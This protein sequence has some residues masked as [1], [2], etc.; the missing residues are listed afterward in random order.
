MATA[1]CRTTS[2]P[3]C[4][5]LEAE[6]FT[7]ANPADVVVETSTEVGEHVQTGKQE[8]WLE[9]ALDVPVAGRYRCEFLVSAT[10]PEASCWL[11]DYPENP[12]GRTYNITGMMKIPPADD[13]ESFL[14][15]HRDGAPL[16]RGL[17][18]VRFHF[19]GGP[20]SLDWIRLTL[21]REHQPTPKTLVQVMSGDEWVQKWSDE[22]DGSGVPDPSI[23]THDIGNWG[24][25]NNE[26]Q[27]YTENREENARL[28]D[29]H[30]IIEARKNDL[31]QPWT[32]ARLTTRGKLSFLYGKIEI[33]AKAPAGQG[34]WAAG[35]TLGDAYVDEKSWPYCGEIDILECVGR[36]VDAASGRGVNH[37]S[38][39]TRAYYFKQGNQISSTI[40]V[41]NMSEEFHTYTVEWYPDRIEA[42]VDGEHY[43][44]YD[45]TN[46][47]WE[48]P[49]NQSQNLILNLAMGGGMGGEIDPNITSQRL[50]VDYVRVFERK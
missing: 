16:N 35:W 29:G 19:Q 31:G 8:G 21:I 12:D 41:E 22:F 47:E 9:F 15:V 5:Q 18:N 30:L 37:A 40:P 38:C 24:W 49:F 4:V 23:W 10:T 50:V 25:G 46:G 45:K 39:H 36:E 27:Y 42:L 44:T 33:R 26:P 32:S 13:A 17:H 34:T 2:Q 1:G 43:Y 14:V 20:V 48:W 7:A 3:V 11:E 28:E 6:R